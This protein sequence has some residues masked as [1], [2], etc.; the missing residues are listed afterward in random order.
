MGETSGDNLVMGAY[1]IGSNDGGYRAILVTLGEA[2]LVSVVIAEFYG[3]Q[4]SYP[5]DHLMS[6]IAMKVDE[7]HHV[8]I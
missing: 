5:S 8:R 1:R 2:N 3:K 6:R 4:P 7:P